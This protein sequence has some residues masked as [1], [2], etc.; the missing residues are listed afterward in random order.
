MK[1]KSYRV[2]ILIFLTGIMFVISGCRKSEVEYI[3]VDPQNS[4]QGP[5]VFTGR[6][7]NIKTE[8]E[9]TMNKGFAPSNFYQ[10][11]SPLKKDLLGGSLPYSS[12]G[13][14][15]FSALGKVYDYFQHKQEMLWLKTTLDN[16]QHELDSIKSEMHYLEDQLQLTQDVMINDINAVNTLNQIA[17]IQTA[18]G[19]SYM[20]LRYYTDAGSN[21]QLGKYDSSKMASM[22]NPHI[23]TFVDNIYLNSDLETVQ[24]TLGNLINGSVYLGFD[25]SLKSYVKLILDQMKTKYTDPKELM[26]GYELL[27]NYFQYILTYQFQACIVKVNVLNFK[28]PDSTGTQ[29]KNYINTFFAP[30]IQQELNSF[31]GAVDYYVLSIY[32]YRYAG[33][34]EYDMNYIDAGLSPDNK[35]YDIL[36]RARFFSNIYLDALGLPC[37][38]I[39][40]EIILPRYYNQGTSPTPSFVMQAN[41]I[42]L[43]TP[44]DTIIAS[45]IPYTSWTQANSTQY[46]MNYQYDNQWRIFRFA[47]TDTSNVWNNSSMLLQLVDNNSQTF[48]WVHTKP[49]KGTLSLLYYNP[50]DPSQSSTVRTK[51]CTMKF[52]YFSSNWRWGFM[53][54]YYT[55][56]NASQLFIPSFVDTWLYG[57][58]TNPSGYKGGT[59]N[60]GINVCQFHSNQ[61]KCDDYTSGYANNLHPVA[62]R[63]FTEEFSSGF[64]QTG[65]SWVIADMIGFTATRQHGILQDGK[66]YA[67]CKY[68]ISNTSSINKT[69]HTY[70]ALMVGTQAIKQS[71]LVYANNCSNGDQMYKSQNEM[72][73]F[74][75]R[76]V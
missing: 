49:I 12:I 61:L 19:T 47:Q 30:L 51:A 70:C 71:D 60:W 35:F 59:C 10:N 36:S 13:S 41:G 14:G 76:I 3:P 1:T 31:L 64:D 73:R 46:S 67:F 38:V 9:Q 8:F 4:D 7:L 63:G 29:G 24:N 37:P 54:L 40:G 21:Y 5:E 6:K 22:I 69:D 17:T 53:K 45:Q 56:R 18:F 28:F 2:F 65:N 33:Q 16:F 52:G 44:Y 39:C 50:Y 74:S 26:Y 11:F 34:Y 62:N 72:Y 58:S 66:V 23:N 48:P 42:N 15:I 43:A 75:K 20:G 57:Q 25:G 68:F 55:D 32:D 27:E